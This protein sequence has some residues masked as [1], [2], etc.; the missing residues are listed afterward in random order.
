MI[1]IPVYLG[2]NNQKVIKDECGNDVF[3]YDSSGGIDQ[4]KSNTAGN[5]ALSKGASI[6][7]S[8]QRDDPKSYYRKRIHGSSPDLSL[9]V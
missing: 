4:S 9:Q 5:P 8:L 2:I 7:K 6:E 3:G 1:T